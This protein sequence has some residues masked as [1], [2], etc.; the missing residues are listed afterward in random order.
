M[1]ITDNCDPMSVK[2]I[3]LIAQKIAKW[4]L[5]LVILKTHKPEIEKSAL[6]FLKFTVVFFYPSRIVEWKY[7]SDVHI[8]LFFVNI[9]ELCET[10]AIKLKRMISV[11]YNRP[12]SRVGS[13][14]NFAC[15]KPGAVETVWVQRTVF[16]WRFRI[17]F[18]GNWRFY[19]THDARRDF[20]MLYYPSNLRDIEKF[21][22]KFLTRPF[23][24]RNGVKILLMNIHGG[25]EYFCDIHSRREVFGHVRV[26][27]SVVQTLQ[28]FG[29]V[30]QTLTKG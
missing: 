16:A 8:V 19:A 2:L 28:M 21:L 3:L 7:E 30:R 23:E 27:F 24:L 12:F 10:I 22:R 5:Y 17:E 9:D 14:S 11:S 20:H 6:I 18:K 15:F 25:M 29:P 13:P 1:F 26:Y 4:I